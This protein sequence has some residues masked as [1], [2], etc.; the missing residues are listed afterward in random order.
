MTPPI[1]Y[2]LLAAL[3][4]MALC[5]LSGGSFWR[6]AVPTG[7]Q[8]EAA[9]AAVE[10][11]AMAFWWRNAAPGYEYTLKV[12]LMAASLATILLGWPRMAWADNPALAVFLGAVLGLAYVGG[13]QCM[14]NAGEAYRAEVARPGPP[15][16][17]PAHPGPPSPS[18][19]PSCAP[20][21][22]PKP[23]AT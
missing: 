11:I 14:G 18:P 6:W 22:T 16:P 21:A 5:L 3:A 12:G 23:R 10:S 2:N 4:G 7:V 1:L 20:P 9:A 17:T 8:G 13:L 19:W 15:R